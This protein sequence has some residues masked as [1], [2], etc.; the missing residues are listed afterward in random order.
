MSLDAVRFS[1]ELETEKPD[2]A[3]IQQGMIEQFE[4][5]QSI[6]AKDYGRAVRGVHAKSHGIVVGKLEVLGGLPPQLAQGAFTTPGTHDVVLRFSTNPGDI[7]DDSVST[8]RG[9][10]MKIFDVPGERLPDADGSTQDFVM[11]DAPAFVA[12]DAAAFLKNLKMLAKTTDTPQ[13]FKKAMSAL[14][15]GIESVLE[16]LGT[17]SGTIIALGG[18]PEHH[19]LGETF[20][21]QVPVRWGDHVAKV[22]LAP[23]SRELADLAGAKLNVNGKPNGLREAVE[24]FFASHEG[25]WELRAQLLTDRDSMPIEDASVPW[26]EDKSPY[27]PVARVTVPPQESWSEAS[28]KAVDEGYAFSPWHGIAAH[29]PLGSIMRARKAVYPRSA[30]FRAAHNGCPMHEPMHAPKV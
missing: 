20:Y 13:I 5:I 25:V 1:P 17:K 7:L 4:H 3:A 22:S 27:V 8:P 2:E 30:G 28:Q 9:L 18:H 10:A 19:I 26:P 29:Q 23:V 6:T 16:S 11:A 15:R 24:D 12:P 21:S 14:M